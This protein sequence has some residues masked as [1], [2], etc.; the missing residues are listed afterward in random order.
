MVFGGVDQQFIQ[1]AGTKREKPDENHS[2][3]GIFW[4]NLEEKDSWSVTLY[5]TAVGTEGILNG[6]NRKVLI[7]SG[8][9]KIYVPGITKFNE[10]MNFLGLKN[11]KY[12]G[13]DP[14]FKCDYK[15]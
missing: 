14:I 1:K 12:D 8:A 10:I 11:M 15:N 4:M 5:E 3:D 2:E 6:Q 13:S 7:D 9:S